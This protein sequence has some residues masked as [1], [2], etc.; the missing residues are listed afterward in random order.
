[1]EIQAFSSTT[2]LKS[3][4]KRFE[5]RPVGATSFPRI[6]TKSQAI[7]KAHDQVHRCRKLILL[8]PVIIRCD[9]IGP[10]PLIPDL[11]PYREI[12]AEKMHIPDGMTRIR[13]D[14]TLLP[15][16]GRAG[17]TMTMTYV[18]N[19]ITANSSVIMGR[20]RGTDVTLLRA[21]EALL[22]SVA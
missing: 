5:K 4:R 15:H 13:G 8:R 10:C 3:M 1:M 20:G 12:G 11:G 7:L 2:N 16:R 6:R 17:A 22:S 21:P 9:P 19:S 18:A 14:K